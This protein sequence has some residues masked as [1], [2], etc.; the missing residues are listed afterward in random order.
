LTVFEEKNVPAE[1][2]AILEKQKVIFKHE[3]A[4]DGGTEYILPNFLPLAET[5]QADFDLFTFGLT[6]PAF[7]LH[8]QDFLPVGLIN[9]L[10]CFFGRQPDRKKFWR[11]QIVFLLCQI[12]N[13]KK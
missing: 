8:F 9:Q 3:Y 4:D 1:I 7:V 13:F 6:N 5:E 10:I 2:L 11:N 12:K